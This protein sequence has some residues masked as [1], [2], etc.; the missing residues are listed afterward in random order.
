[1]TAQP[2]ALSNANI[3]SFITSDPRSVGFSAIRTAHPGADQPLIDAANNASGPGAGT[4]AGDPITASALLDLIDGDEFN[5][6]TT[7]QLTQLQTILAVQT[8]DAGTT[9]TQGK[10]SALFSSYAKSLASVQASYTRPAGPWEVYF[11]KGNVATAQL[12]DAARNSGSGNN[13]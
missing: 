9:P 4:V 3:I 10:L 11:G 6:M 12:L 1:M 8:V 2:V 7:A 5:T 13:F